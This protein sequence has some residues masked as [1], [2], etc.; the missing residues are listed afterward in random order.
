MSAGGAAS[1]E[2]RTHTPFCG[3]GVGI[4]FFWW[5]DCVEFFVVFVV[6]VGVVLAFDELVVVIV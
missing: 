5:M 6:G 4:Y 3:G 2:G 1:A